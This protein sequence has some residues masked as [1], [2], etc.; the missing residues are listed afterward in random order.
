VVGIANRYVLD[1]RRIGTRVPTGSRIFSSP[2][3]PD[4]LWGQPNLISNGYVGSFPG[5]KA[6]EQ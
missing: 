6:A 1:D 3:L 5:A 2:R 4:W